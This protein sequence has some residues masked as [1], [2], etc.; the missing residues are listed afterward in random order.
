MKEISLVIT[1]A[2]S[3][4]IS[5]MVAFG[6]TQEIDMAIAEAFYS[7]RSPGLTTLMEGLTY[8]G[9]WESITILCLLLLIYPKTRFAYGIPVSLAAL[10]TTAIKAVGKAAIAR[11]RPDMLFHLIEQGGY[12][13]PSGHAITG[14][15]V[16]IILVIMVGKHMGKGVEV[17]EEENKGDAGDNRGNRR[18]TNLLMIFL[19]I[20]AFGI[21]LSRIYLGVHYPCDVLGS[22]AAGLAVAV[23]VWMFMDFLEKKEWYKKILKE[24]RYNNGQST[25]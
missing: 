11:P 23:A 5:F 25:E 24:D 18:K 22:W 12:S 1:V 21:G 2:V 14:F 10:I 4:F 8:L 17:G 9:N 16:C 6:Y 20:P 19:L 15:S 3:I 7:V 13:Y